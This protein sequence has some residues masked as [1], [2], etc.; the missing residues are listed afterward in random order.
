[1]VRI[2]HIVHAYNA[3]SKPIVVS[4]RATFL[5]LIENSSSLVDQ[6]RPSVRYDMCH[7]VSK[8]K[9]LIKLWLNHESAIAIYVPDFIII[10]D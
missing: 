5:I 10:I 7:A 8:I 3:I 4:P 1:M 6:A 2:P 9:S